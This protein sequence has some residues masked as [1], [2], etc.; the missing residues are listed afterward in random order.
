MVFILHGSSEIGAQVR[1]SFCYLICSRH[2]IR[3]RAVINPYFF[4]S[5]RS[6]FLQACATCSEIPSE[7]STMATI[8]TNFNKSFSVTKLG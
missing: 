6:I 2:L 4:S 3:P 1:S 7:I 5:N 8:V